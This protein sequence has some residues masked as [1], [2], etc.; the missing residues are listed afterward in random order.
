MRFLGL[1]IGTRRTGVAFADSED[2]ILFSI[3]TL[4]HSSEQELFD[5]VCRTVVLRSIDEVVL[6]YPLLLS[7]ERGSQAEIVLHFQELLIG[8]KIPCSLVDERYTTTANAK[9]DKDAASACEILTL[10]LKRK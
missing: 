10:R 6:G 7:G 4:S 2:D 8:A 1:D 9:Y 5:Y 3:E